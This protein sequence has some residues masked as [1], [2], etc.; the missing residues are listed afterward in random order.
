MGQTDTKGCRTLKFRSDIDIDFADRQQVLDLL[1]VTSASIIRDGKLVKHNTGVYATDIPV[2]PFVGS[3]SLDYQVA[4]DRGYMK[5]DLLN[6]HVYKQVRDETHLIKLMQ[7]P[8][9]TML[10][11]PT[12][13]SQL[14]HINNHYDTLLKM[15]EPVD[16]I[17]RLAMFLAVIRPAKRHLIGR[18][19]KEIAKT[20]WDKVD[21][22]YAFKAAH[23]I[24]YAQLVV[25]NLNLL[26]E[27]A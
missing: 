11:D 2:D 6:V 9:W 19:W 1:N 7:E 24:A 15:P 25:V 23:A 16:S 14:I 5:L 20:V 18:T 12:I 22:E 13:C 17:P 10:Y 27:S 21:G 4:E 8:D 26:C 3:A